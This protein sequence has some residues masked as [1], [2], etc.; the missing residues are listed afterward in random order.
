MYQ[1]RLYQMI[2]NMIVLDCFLKFT[3]NLMPLVCSGLELFGRIFIFTPIQ[4]KH[5][6]WEP[7]L[8]M[9]SLPVNYIISLCKIWKILGFLY[10]LILGFWHVH[11]TPNPELHWDSIIIISTADSSDIWLNDYLICQC[12]SSSESILPWWYGIL[13]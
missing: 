11:K 2:E 4:S 1:T 10:Y 9:I 12:N 6:L 8:L 5:F 3:Q 7:I 13:K